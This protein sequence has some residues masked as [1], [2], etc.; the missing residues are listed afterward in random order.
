VTELDGWRS[1]LPTPHVTAEKVIVGNTEW[2]KA[3][4]FGTADRVEF[5]LAIL[6]LLTRSVFI[7]RMRFVAPNAN[8]ERLGDG[9]DNW[10]FNY[11]GT[12]SLWTFDI[13]RI[14]LDEGSFTFVDHDK[15][16]DVS[17]KVDALGQSI[18][19][20]DLVTQQIRQSREEIAKQIGAKGTAARAARRQAHRGAQAARQG[21]AT[22]CIFVDRRGHLCEGSLQ[23]HWQGRRRILSE[24]RGST[25][26]DAGR[27]PDWRHADRVRR[28]AD[29]STR[30]RFARP[31]L[32]AVRQQLVAA[33]QY[34]AHHDAEFAEV[35]DGRPPR[36]PFQA[37]RKQAAL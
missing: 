27:W 23:G 30:P 17:G 3:H 20:D 16:I 24:K 6:P 33:L 12:P 5:D 29:R 34:R 19:F 21:A 37:R 22:L 8:L 2:G 35:R 18:A 13:G 4:E 15:A 25:V 32:V 14:A 31:A 26:P 1:W 28:D 7:E 11:D 36:R 10:T 9:R